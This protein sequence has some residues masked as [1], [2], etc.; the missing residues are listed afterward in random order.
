MVTNNCKQQLA[1]TPDTENNNDNNISTAY[2]RYVAGH[3]SGKIT[4]WVDIHYNGTRQRSTIDSSGISVNIARYHSRAKFGCSLVVILE[5]NCGIYITLCLRGSMMMS[6]NG[7]IFRVTGQIFAE[8]LPK[9]WPMTPGFL[10]C[11][12]RCRLFYCSRLIW[13]RHQMETFSPL[14][15]TC[16]GNSPGTGEFPTQRPVTCSFDVFFDL[17]LNKRLSKHW[18]G[19]WFETPSCPLW[20]H[21]N[22][23]YTTYTDGVWNIETFGPSGSV[24]FLWELC[25]RV[26][27]SFETTD[28]QS[29]EMV[30]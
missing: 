14:L 19:W 27:K 26:N 25:D 9:C 28:N 15:A 21:C 20:R 29:S 3:F 1:C 4:F 8:T 12:W 17:H 24:C 5:K 7:N 23:R 18:W 6:S 10:K 30:Y 2:W 16:A 11:T 22:E 13:W